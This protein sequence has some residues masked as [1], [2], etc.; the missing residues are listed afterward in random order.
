M[1]T[2]TQREN[3]KGK[4]YLVRVRL[5]GGKHIAKTFQT[6][7]RAY[8]WM[9]ST[10]AAI[11]E[12]RFTFVNEATKYTVSDMIKRYIETELPKKPKSFD[13]Q[14]KQLGW[15]D[16][17]IGNLYLVR[18][19]RPMLIECRDKLAGEMT[20]R[21]KLRAPATV[22]RYLAVMSHCLN[23]TLGDWEWIEESPMK[24][25]LKLKEPPGRDRILTVQEMK[26]L[27]DG[28]EQSRSEN[29]FD[30]FRLALATGMRKGEV[31]GLQWKDVAF[32]R[33][34]L[35]LRET[36]NGQI[37]TAH[38]SLEIRQMLEERFENRRIDSHYVFPSKDGKKPAC[39]RRA[40][41]LVRKKAGLDGGEVVFHTLRHTAASYMAMDGASDAELRKFLGHLSMAMTGRYAHYRDDALKPA[42]DRLS[43]TIATAVRGKQD[44][45]RSEDASL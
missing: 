13:K 12:G 35:I 17:Q 39:T 45:G 6:K 2:I 16:K 8:D 19:R 42:V 11:K 9:I 36:K 41:E 15:W 27:W 43:D 21:G 10:E 28:C 5:K 38:M 44:E 26:I 20:N 22:N 7:S 24:G 25:S 31:L 40:W 4:S 32:D 23:V 18:L 37:R 29:L 14:S 1:G 34:M 3:K 30:S 33:S